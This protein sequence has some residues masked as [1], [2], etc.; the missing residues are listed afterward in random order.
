MGRNYGAEEQGA[1]G[2]GT[3]GEHSL[4]ASRRRLVSVQG[5]RSPF[6]RAADEG[7]NSLAAAVQLGE[8]RSRVPGD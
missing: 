4:V 2:S 1:K 7:S 6:R 5:G 3:N 8:Q